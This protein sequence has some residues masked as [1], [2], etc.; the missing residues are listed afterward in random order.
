MV[1]VHRP[2]QGVGPGLPFQHD[3]PVA[4][5]GQEDGE[6]VADGSVPDHG[7]VDDL[8]GGALGGADHG[9]VARGVAGGVATHLGQVPWSWAP[10][11]EAGPV[12][13]PTG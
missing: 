2:G 5:L 10:V 9:A 4:E 1:E 7:H 3:D 13:A 8:A 11:T 12:G 6:R